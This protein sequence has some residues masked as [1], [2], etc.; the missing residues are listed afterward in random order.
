MS[1]YEN[2]RRLGAAFVLALFALPV[3]LLADSFAVSQLDGSNGVAVRGGLTPDD[4]GRSV[5]A[6]GDINGDGFDDFVV[7]S[8]TADPN[9]A[10]SGIVDIVFG[11]ANPLPH[12]LALASLDDTEKVR[13]L[14]AGQFDYAGFSVANAG[15]INS[16]GFNDLVLGAP[17]SSLGAQF[18]G[19]VYLIFGTDQGFESPIDLSLPGDYHVIAGIEENADAG[20]SVAGAGDVNGDGTDDLVIGARFANGSSGAAYVV[21]GSA[22]ELPGSFDVLNGANGFAMASVGLG[23]V[24]GQSVAGGFDLNGDGYDDIAIGAPLAGEENNY[25]GKAYIVFG[26]NQPFGATLNLNA[27]DGSNGLTINGAADQDNFGESVAVAGNIDLEGFDDLIIGAPQASPGGLADAG[28]SYVIFGSG[29]P[30][31]AELN[32]ATLDGSNGF[33]LVGDEVGAQSGAAVAGGFDLNR[34]GIDDAVVG[35]PKSDLSQVD[36]GAAYVVH[37]KAGGWSASIFLSGLSG[38]S[39]QIIAGKTGGDAFGAAVSA[40]GDLNN[41]SWIDLIAGAPDASTYVADA[42]EAYLIYS[43][44]LSN[45]AIIFA[46]GFE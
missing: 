17:A 23:D 28:S 34:D 46:N 5:S 39:G 8:P 1:N 29:T 38:A 6:A 9:G 35:A 27:L 15:D 33:A 37:G 44:D 19:A 40:A 14:G 2:G 22:G 20:S 18:G 25:T 11:Q 30:Y 12:P 4:L 36:S 21:F 43:E 45:P 7:A 10:D 24:L 13:I 41:D 16:D 42:G 32:V 3:S 26:S 31:A